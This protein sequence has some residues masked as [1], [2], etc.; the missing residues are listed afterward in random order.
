MSEPVDPHEMGWAPPPPV[1]AGYAQ[2]G[3][4]P[5]YPPGNG[6]IAA[7]PQQSGFA[8]IPAPLPTS[9]GYGAPPLWEAPPTPR[10]RRKVLAA[11]GAL[12]A[13]VIIA[14]V[15]V[16]GSGSSTPPSGAPLPVPALIGPYQQR[17]DAL[18][19]RIRSSF[20]DEAASQTGELQRF[21]TRAQ[22]GVYTQNLTNTDQPTLVTIFGRSSAYPT[23]ASAGITGQIFGPAGTP[24]PEDAGT[25]GGALLC[26]DDSFSVGSETICTWS[27]D[28]SVGFLVAT[29]VTIS[30]QD[31]AALTNQARDIIDG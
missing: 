24:V 31:L 7:P 6:P 15:V 18:L 25:H 27:D 14:V 22:I 19:D 16:A 12:A 23:I 10:R 26:S 29:Q 3:Y 21:L 8:P 11:G 28:T 2:P 20:Q 5:R 30:P 4:G 9:A 13:A 1:P 17:T